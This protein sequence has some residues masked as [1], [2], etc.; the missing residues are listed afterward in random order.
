ISLTTKQTPTR[1]HIPYTTLLR[2]PQTQ[3]AQSL[4]KAR[5]AGILRDPSKRAPLFPT[6]LSDVF[7]EPMLNVALN[8]ARKA[9]RMAEQAAERR[10]EED[11]AELQSREN[12]VC[13]RMPE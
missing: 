2:T 1:A 9:A 11:T 10:S 7:M 5:E 12:L 4:A 13:R 3:R 6:T 8:A